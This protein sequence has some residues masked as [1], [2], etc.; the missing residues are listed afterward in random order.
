MESLDVLDT[1]YR[2]LEA[3][4]KTIGLHYKG[5]EGGLYKIVDEINQIYDLLT[6]LRKKIREECLG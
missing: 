4:E 2:R 3:L 1:I 5:S 6:I